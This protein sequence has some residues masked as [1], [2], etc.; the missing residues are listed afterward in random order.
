M[1]HWID[2][3]TVAIIG[4]AESLF[5]MFLGGEIDA[6]DVVIRINRSA[7]ICYKKD[8]PEIEKTHGV[9]TDIWAFSFADTMKD[10]LKQFHGITDKLIQMNPANKNKLL[11][12]FSFDAILRDDITDLNKRLNDF[13]RKIDSEFVKRELEKMDYD[14]K[15]RY[16]KKHRSYLL[17][18]VMKQDLIQRSKRDVDINRE[19]KAS[20]GMRV[21][22]WV[23]S[24]EPESV[25]VYGFDW[26][27]T[28]TFYDEKKNTR[29]TEKR[30]NHNYFL[31]F[32]YCKSYFQDEKGFIFVTKKGEGI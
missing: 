1:N 2:R 26:K 31:E 11:F 30:H 13:K 6:H 27:E 17:E 20:T 32:D 7:S 18:S 8:Y 29:K 16:I 15:F 5:E 21:L 4:N 19:Y 14:E 28:P 9:K 23:S 22:D 25:R 12:D 3:K 24:H 10:E